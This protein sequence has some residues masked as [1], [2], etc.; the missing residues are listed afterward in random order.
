[1]Y[2]SGLKYDNVETLT[3]EFDMSVTLSSVGSDRTTT[4]EYLCILPV[5]LY[6]ATGCCTHLGNWDYATSFDAL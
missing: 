6:V 1:M 3:D 4:K 5:S 2:T